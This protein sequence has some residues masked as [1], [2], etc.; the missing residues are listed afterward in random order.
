MFQKKRFT[1][2]SQNEFFQELQNTDKV[3][4]KILHLI[5]CSHFFTKLVSH[6]AMGL[7]IILAFRYAISSV[8]QVLPR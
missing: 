7:A 6:G 1:E 8:R 2:V 5:G 3:Q 4:K